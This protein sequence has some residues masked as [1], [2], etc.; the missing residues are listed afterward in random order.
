MMSR[1]LALPIALALVCASP[2]RAATPQQHVAAARKAEK[3]GDWKKALQEWQA[4]YRLE[5]NAEYLVSMGDCYARL[6]NVAEARKQ[7]EAYL[8]DPLALPAT[9][10]AVRAKIAALDQPKGGALAVELPS[11]PLPLPA[12]EAAKPA[13][14]TPPP[15]E[16]KALP[17]PDIA[18]ASPPKPAASAPA[19]P[20]AAVAAVAKPPVQTTPAAIPAADRRVP[21]EAI[22]VDY[23][24][25]S[26]GRTQRV[27]AWVTAG[28][29]V[30]AIGGGVYAYTKANSAQNDL[31]SQVRSGAAAQQLLESEKQNRTL[32]AIGFAGGL[33]A[34]G[35][36]AAL[37]AF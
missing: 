23:R 19:K 6:G 2:A 15:A 35:I 27:V 11:A 12:A 29:A 28:V 26:A 13:A 34:A 37:F 22:A 16:A 9:M 18:P 33:V 24:P 4:A 14:L 20:P 17:L 7:Y 32:S 8:G 21:G 10:A 3:R 1:L 30:A 36:S 5:I 25:S 31:T